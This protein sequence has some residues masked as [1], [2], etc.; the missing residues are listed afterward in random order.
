MKF[1]G[2]CRLGVKCAYK[3]QL[4]E[5]PQ[6]ED[7]NENIKNIKAE[8]DV[9]KNTVKALMSIKEEGKLLHQ[10][11]K[12]LKEEIMFLIAAN[13]HTKEKISELQDDLVYDTEEEEETD[14]TLLGNNRFEDFEELFQIESLDGEVVYACNVC[15]EGLDT[16]TD[17]KQHIH[18]QHKNI[19]QTIRK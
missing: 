14:V 16:K 19:L 13:N 18:I 10:D 7:T 2:Y 6:H 12:Y 3:H 15:D 8:L 4:K 11:V 9:L 17:V 1:Y 5:N